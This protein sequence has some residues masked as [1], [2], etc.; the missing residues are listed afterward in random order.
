MAIGP[1]LSLSLRRMAFGRGPDLFCDLTLHAAKGEVLALTGP[2]GIGKTTLLRIMAGVETG[3]DGSVTVDGVAARLAP[4]PGFVFQDA[5]LLPWCSAAQNLRAVRPDLKD[6]QVDHALYSVGLAGQ[7]ALLP[8]AMSGGMQR[9]LGIARALAVHHGLLLLDE[10][11]VSLDPAL[12]RDLQ[13]LVLGIVNDARATTVLVTHDA[14][15]AARLAHRVV[16]LGG[17]PGRVVADIA[18]SDSLAPIPQRNA[19]EIAALTAQIEAA[20]A[21]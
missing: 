21:A 18:L 2:S 10:P 9:R 13:D 19:A 11:F 5:R 1:G 17:R 14:R 8:R 6:A 15:E 20:G 3:F 12:Q 7:G 4:V 16:V